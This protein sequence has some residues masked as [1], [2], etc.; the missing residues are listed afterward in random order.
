MYEQFF[1]FK[2]GTI[3]NTTTDFLIESSIGRLDRMFISSLHH[4]A[5]I[6]TDGMLSADAINL[7]MSCIGRFLKIP[8]SETQEANFQTILD[9]IKD[10]L[11]E[12][13]Q[14]PN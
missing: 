6:P 3:P 8:L 13:N 5:V 10:S 12:L 1:F 7:L 11:P 4:P 2:Q 9:L 14:K